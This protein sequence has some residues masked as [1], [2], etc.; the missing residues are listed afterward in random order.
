[1]SIFYI[2]SRR[3]VNRKNKGKDIIPKGKS[4][5]ILYETYV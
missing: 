2:F 1:M 4:I 3:T 5:K